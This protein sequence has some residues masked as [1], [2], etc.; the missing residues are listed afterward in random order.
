MQ[1]NSSPPHPSF[2]SPCADDGALRPVQN[3]WSQLKQTRRAPTKALCLVRWLA[4]TLLCMLAVGAFAAGVKVGDVFPDF[5]GFKLEG[6]LPELK[7]KVVLVDFWASW[8]DP[9]K[10]SFPAMEELQKK[11]GPQG[12]VILAVNVDEDR[13][14]M[15]TFLKK[16]P[17]TFSVIRD[18]GQ[19]LVERVQAS[20]MPTSFLLDREGKIRFIHSGFH[21]EDTRKKYAQEI[22]SL[23]KK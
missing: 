2:Q 18:A 23:L 7:N 6:K 22:E 4:G 11:Y 19:K 21:G 3:A 13:K 15:E 9:C 20:T 10:A 1:T 17:A 16:N 12:F 5:S 8:C 14:D